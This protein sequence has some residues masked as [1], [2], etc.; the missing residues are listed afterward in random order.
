MGA[1]AFVEE[2]ILHG[3]VFRISEERLG[4]WVAPAIS[5]LLFAVLQLASPGATVIGASVAVVE[6]G[7]LLSAA[8]VL[9]RRLRLAIGIQFAWALS[10]DAIFGIG[11][12]AKGLLRGELGGPVRSA[13]EPGGRL[14]AHS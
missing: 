12:S 11:K 13:V 7:I 8:F 4:T 10:Q 14:R 6:G 3:V 1:G 2:V 9:T 5:V